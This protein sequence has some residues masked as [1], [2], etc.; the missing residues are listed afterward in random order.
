MVERCT[1]RT[2]NVLDMAPALA[3]RNDAHLSNE[4]P[5]APGGFVAWKLARQATPLAERG[6]IRGGGGCE[7]SLLSP[8][9]QAELD[10]DAVEALRFER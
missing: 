3:E 9:E 1:D 2:G 4:P 5:D 8:A 6:E 7:H 10:A